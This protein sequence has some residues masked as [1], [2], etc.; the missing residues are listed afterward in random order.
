MA[1]EMSPRAGPETAPRSAIVPSEGSRTRIRLVRLYVRL[2]RPR[3]RSM[4]RLRDN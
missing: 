3:S 4:I 1:E 2:G